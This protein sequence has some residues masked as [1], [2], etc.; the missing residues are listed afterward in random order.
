MYVELTR[1]DVTHN[2]KNNTFIFL[3]N[4]MQFFEISVC[5]GDDLFRFCLEFMG[6][7]GASF[8]FIH[9]SYLFLNGDF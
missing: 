2:A 1:E 7:R 9:L 3:I 5:Y 4:N 6:K 8:T